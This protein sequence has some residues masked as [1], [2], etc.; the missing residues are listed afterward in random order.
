MGSPRGN[1]VPFDN[2]DFTVIY[3]FLLHRS[4]TK[5]YDSRVNCLG[6]IWD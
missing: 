4:H 6:P 1:F 2:V 3:N 5:S